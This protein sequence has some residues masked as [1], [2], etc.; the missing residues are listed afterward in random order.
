[1][2]SEHN[3]K[4]DTIKLGDGIFTAADVSNILNL[5]Y[6]KVNYWF[7]RY[8]RDRYNLDYSFGWGYYQYQDIVAVNFYTMIELYV[9]YQL[10]EHNVSPK[11][12]LKLHSFLSDFYKTRYPFAKANILVHGKQVLMSHGD[13]ITLADE[14]FQMVFNEIVIPFSKHIEFDNSD[15]LARKFYPLGKD[16]N[17]VVNKDNQFG[18]PIIDK[19][20]IKISTILSFYEGGETIESIAKMY[21][22]NVAQVKDAIEYA[23]L[24]NAA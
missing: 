13:N 9:F 2:T 1:M 15:G 7:R 8:L 23:H 5:D 19:T 10:R 4:K 11:K 16:K 21:S 18:Q 24:P 20:N 17:V 14:T 6:S 12:I 3:I 22:L